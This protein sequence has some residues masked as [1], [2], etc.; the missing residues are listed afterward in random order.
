MMNVALKTSSGL[1]Q[2]SDALGLNG[3]YVGTSFKEIEHKFVVEKGFDRK[4]FFKALEVLSPTRTSEVQ[5]EDTYFVLKDNFSYVFRH[6]FDA[7]IQQL[8]VKSV[9]PTSEVRTE[10]NLNLTLAPGNQLSHARAFL[11]TFGVSW[12]QSLHKDVAVA[13]FPDCE[14]VHYRARCGRREVECVEFEA[15]GADSLAAARNVLES[16]ES[17]L[18]F[19]N[20]PRETKTLF[21]L[22]LLVD[23]PQDVKSMFH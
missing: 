23:A 16:Y 12:S 19:T 8:T 17:K 13:Y 4:E 11:E 10:I 7:E 20:R 18:G 1:L 9:E 2:S 15:I 3:F 22:L 21:E 5:V 6:R 14:I